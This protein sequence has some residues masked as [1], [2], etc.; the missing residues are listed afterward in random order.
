MN[1]VVLDVVYFSRKEIVVVLFCCLWVWFVVLLVM[2]CQQLQ[3]KEDNAA[4]LVAR[5][6]PHPRFNPVSNIIFVP[7]L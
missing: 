6:H 4:G 2:L 3:P 1:A 7:F 5:L